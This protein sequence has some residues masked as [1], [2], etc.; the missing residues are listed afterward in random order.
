MRKLSAAAAGILTGVFLALSVGVQAGL[1]TP[2]E[3]AFVPTDLHRAQTD[4]ASIQLRVLK[5]G[6]LA[7]QHAPPVA[8]LR[9]SVTLPRFRFTDVPGGHPVTPVQHRPASSAFSLYPTGPPA[10]R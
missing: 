3:Q 2:V 7:G 5:S 6:H 9:S 10:Q 8:P 4:Q 1:R